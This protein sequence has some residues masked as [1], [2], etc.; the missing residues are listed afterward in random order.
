[1]RFFTKIL[2]TFLVIDKVFLIFPFIFQIL[3]IYTVLNVVYDPFYTRKTTIS[4]KNSLTTPFFYSV[5]TFARIR[6]HYFSKYWVDGCMRRPPT[7][8]IFGGTSP[9]SP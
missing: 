7:S 3:R 8:N 9:Q 5:R 1:M 6:Q 4:Q 2:M